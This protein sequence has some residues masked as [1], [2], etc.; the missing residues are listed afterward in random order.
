MKVKKTLLIFLLSFILISCGASGKK[1][2]PDTNSASDSEENTTD[3]GKEE[4]QVPDHWDNGLSEGVN[5]GIA[6]DYPNDVGIKNHPKVLAAEDFESGSVTI[7]TEEDRYANNVSVVDSKSYTGKFS[8]ERNWAEGDNGPTTR[9]RIPDSAHEGIRSTY[10]VRMCFN[11]DHSF[12]PGED[13]IDA[14]VGVKGFGIVAESETEDTGIMTPCN[15]KNWYNAQVQFVGWGPSEKPQAND[16][17]LWVGHLY[18]Y[19]PSP[20]DAVPALGKIKVSDPAAGDKPYRFSS[21]ADPFFYIDFGGWHCYE[22]GMYLNTP[23]KNDGE[24][25]FWIDGILQSRVTN[26]RYRDIESL[27]PTTMHIN[28]H[29]T[30]ENFP[31]TMTRWTDNIVMAT[32]YIGPVKID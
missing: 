10:F 5:W 18:S 27:K 11:Y 17:Y 8:S 7:V 16:K 19:N 29:R 14:G 20:E 21:Y 4:N 24:A 6:K 25:R 30:T 31:H 15:G 26:I 2:N 23:G 22:V 28:L 12:H 3:Q 9:F 32:R 13:R 1:E